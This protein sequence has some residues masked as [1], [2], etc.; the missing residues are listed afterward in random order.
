MYQCRVKSSFEGITDST[1]MLS[2]TLLSPK[3]RSVSA[4]ISRRI[5]WKSAKIC[6]K[7]VRM[8]Q[9]S[10]HITGETQQ[11][12]RLKSAAKC[13][14]FLQWRN[15]PHSSALTPE[16]TYKSERTYVYRRS[17]LHFG[18]EKCKLKRLQVDW[19]HAWRD[20]NKLNVW[21]S[22]QKKWS[23]ESKTSSCRPN[24]QRPG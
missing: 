13:T 14:W 19:Q 24:I 4:S 17:L 9:W 2:L 8:M 15:V 6:Q 10:Q 23:G 1:A 16:Q 3:L 5:S 11:G 22:S 18:E 7:G 20:Q 12:R 21:E